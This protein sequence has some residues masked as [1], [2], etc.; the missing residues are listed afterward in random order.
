[1][2]D[3]LLSQTSVLGAEMIVMG[4]YHHS[5]VREFMLGRVTRPIVETIAVP[6]LLSH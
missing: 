2:A 3:L 5:R 6:V 4:G 1:M